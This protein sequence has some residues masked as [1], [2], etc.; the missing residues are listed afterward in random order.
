MCYRVKQNVCVHAGV[1]YEVGD[2]MPELAL[3]YLNVH[4]PNLEIVDSTPAPEPTPEPE[5]EV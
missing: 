5:N 3:E 4:L 2:I 1:T